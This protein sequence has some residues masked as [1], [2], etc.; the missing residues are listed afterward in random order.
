MTCIG[1][2]RPDIALKGA[3]VQRKWEPVLGRV[4]HAPAYGIPA[5]FLRKGGTCS[6]TNPVWRP[7]TRVIQV[8]C[9]HG[10][11]PR[12]IQV[13]HP[14]SFSGWND[15][16]ISGATSTPVSVC[17][18]K[19]HDRLP[20][21]F[22]VNVLVLSTYVLNTSS[23]ITPATPTRFYAAHRP[24]TYP[25][26]SNY[27]LLPSFFWRSGDFCCTLLVNT[28]QFALRLSQAFSFS[29]SLLISTNKMVLQDQFL[30]F[31]NDKII[32]ICFY[33]KFISDIWEVISLQKFYQFNLKMSWLQAS[34]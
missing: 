23:N 4:R 3:S 2:P 25:S 17:V 28:F 10:V 27:K 24:G 19:H 7:P 13:Q 12:I 11:P 1:K 31:F 15:V 20:P 6:Y 32:Y 33:N 22:W 30:L 14:I 21:C 9:R 18:I 16:S 26:Y 29:T 34:M 5:V 8:V